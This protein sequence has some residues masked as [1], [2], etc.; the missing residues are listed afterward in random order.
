MLT[1]IRRNYRFFFLCEADCRRMYLLRVFFLS[2]RVAEWSL[3]TRGASHDKV[4]S[5]EHKLM[6][7]K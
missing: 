5:Y 2:L 4:T 6:T 7:G 3:K 1:L